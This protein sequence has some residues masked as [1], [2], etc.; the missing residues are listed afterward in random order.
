MLDLGRLTRDISPALRKWLHLRDG[1]C[2]AGGCDKPAHATDA[3]H[4]RWWRHGG[5]TDRH[6]LVLLC[7]FHHYLV[8]D[9]GWTIEMDTS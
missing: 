9:R 8:H 1:G 3:H 4:I 6:N 5:R 2:R 7:S